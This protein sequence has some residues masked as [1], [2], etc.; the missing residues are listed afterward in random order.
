[1]SIFSTIVK[2]LAA[3]GV[4]SGAAGVGSKIYL[5]NG[6]GFGTMD[7]VS[8]SLAPASENENTSEQ[9][10]QNQSESQAATNSSTSNQETFGSKL[11]SSRFTLVDNSTSDDVILNIIMER[12][13]PTKDKLTYNNKQRFQEN[14][15][16]DFLT[17]TFSS[18]VGGVSYSLTVL[19]KPNKS[20]VEPWKKACIEALKK[21][22]VDDS[23]GT[24][25]NYNELARLR[26]WCT[27]PTIED[28][29]KRH[30]LTPLSTDV[31]QTKDDE[32]WKE[33]IAGGW[34]KKD[35]ETKYWDKQSFITSTQLSDLVGTDGISEKSS[36][37]SSKIDIFK[38]RCK[39]VLAKPF[40]RTNFYL[41]KEFIDGIADSDSPKPT[42]DEFQ[43]AALFC[44]KP[45]KASEYITLSLQGQVSS[46]LATKTN[47]Y[48][49][50]SDTND[51]DTWTTNN[52]LGGKSF[53]CA[54]KSLYV[55]KTSR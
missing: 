36:I 5:K 52:P 26:E 49:Y 2:A 18:S 16:V 10:S 37:D 42:V 7:V 27:I 12:M 39:D 44:V 19:Q 51:R 29:L 1:M 20:V 46:T 32:T 34:F 53:W 28:V 23:T 6:H 8:N 43:E 14:P 22:Y 41:T 47:D 31:S 38:N 24:K 11:Q 3:T 21:P 45:F 30:K 48:C 55:P 50:I 25:V 4:L 13:D 17:K 15:K 54:V 35:G 40:L 33:V 9:S